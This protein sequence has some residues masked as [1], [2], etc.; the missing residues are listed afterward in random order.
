MSERV[1]VPYDGSDHAEAALR[2]AFETHPDATIVVFHVVEP[3]AE[4]TDAGVENV[5]RWQDTAREY[6]ETAFEEAAAVAAEYDRSVETDWE[7]GR[8][9]H[10]IVRYVTDHDVD[11]VV[12]GSRGRNGLDR[13]LLGSIAETVVR[14][15]PVPVTVVGDEELDE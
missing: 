6:A 3:F 5:R 7:Y 13:L 4:H 12:M 1:L 9:Q 2:F 14:R 8:P 10:V 15:V 11:Q